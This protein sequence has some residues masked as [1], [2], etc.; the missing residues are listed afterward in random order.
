MN[1]KTQLGSTDNMRQSLKYLQTS[2]CRFL[3][4]LSLFRPPVLTMA[5]QAVAA[6]YGMDAASTWLSDLGL[7]DTWIT[8]MNFKLLYIEIA[9]WQLLYCALNLYISVYH[10][11]HESEYYLIGTENYKLCQAALLPRRDSGP[12]LREKQDDLWFMVISVHYI[13]PVTII[14]DVISE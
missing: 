7:C 12:H 5:D 1:F 10:T 2:T 13:D 11:K 4:P 9:L 6:T 14:L 8:D 3:E